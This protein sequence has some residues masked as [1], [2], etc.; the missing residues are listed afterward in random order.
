MSTRSPRVGR[1]GSHPLSPGAD[2]LRDHPI[3]RYLE[4]L[5][6]NLA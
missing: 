2:A 3:N 6:K 4:C 5:E 1:D